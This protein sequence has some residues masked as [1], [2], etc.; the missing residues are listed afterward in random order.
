MCERY[1]RA[2]VE[3][4]THLLFFLY[5]GSSSHITYALDSC[6]AMDLSN[7]LL[8][9]ALP[10]TIDSMEN[11]VYVL[12]KKHHVVVDLPMRLLT[13]ATADNPC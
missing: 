3:P 5:S 1:A 6:S 10:S 4:V 2:V 11:L 12:R 13:M 7:N 9:G 8:T